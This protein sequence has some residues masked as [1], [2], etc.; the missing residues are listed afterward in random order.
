VLLSST[1]STASLLV[2]QPIVLE[3]FLILQQ[4]V[5]LQTQKHEISNTKFQ[6][7]VCSVYK[8]LETY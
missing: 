2:L 8:N 5:G 4:N 7:S 6:Y 3:P 1:D